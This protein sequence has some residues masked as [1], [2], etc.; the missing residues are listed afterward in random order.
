MD[1]QTAKERVKELTRIINEHDYKYY[2]LAQPEISDYDYD[3][4]MEEL[5][6]LE[7]KFPEL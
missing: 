2:V 1:L 7:Q 5:I 6:R 4:L 3:M